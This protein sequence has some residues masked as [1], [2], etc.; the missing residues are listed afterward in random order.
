M[1]IFAGPPIP[2]VPSPP[3]LVAPVLLSTMTQDKVLKLLHRST[4]SP[5]VVHPCDT[6]NNSNTK[7]HWTS[8]E[9]HRAMGCQKFQNYRHIL[10]VSW[11]GEWV[12]G[13]KFPP[14]L[15]SFATI[16]KAKRGQSLN[17]TR[18]LYLDAVH[19]DIA[20]GNCL[21]I[22]GFQYALILVDRG[23]VLGT[24][25]RSVLRP[26]PQIPSFWRS[27]SFGPLLVSLHGVSI[28][29]AIPSF[30]GLPLASISWIMPTKSLLPLP[31][32]SLQMALPNPIGR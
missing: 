9:I 10:Q 20:F 2:P 29:T 32:V 5:P 16:P 26:C 13:G 12:D 24:I 8:R 19:M 14:S 6:P 28:V 22:D 3:S 15:A 23:G 1:P 4:S 31:C 30:L 7:M 18:Y 27:V 11:D 25:G 17:C 21:A